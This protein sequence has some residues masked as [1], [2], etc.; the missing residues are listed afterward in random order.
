[1]LNYQALDIGLGNGAFSD[2]YLFQARQN[3]KMRYA[4]KIMFKEDLNPD[5]LQLVNEEVSIL[6]MLD[7]SNIVKYIESYEDDTNLFIV[8]EYLEDATELQKLINQKQEEMDKDPARKAESLFKEDEVCRVMR[9]IFGGLHHIHSNNVVHRDMKPE[10]CL[11]DK[12]GQVRIIDFGLSKMV[13]HAEEGQFLMGTPYFL[14]PE[15]HELEGANEA[16]RQPLDCWS[17]GVLMYHMI[18][19]KYPFDKPDLTEKICTGYV[20][21]YDDRFRN[22]S[23]HAKDLIRKLLTKDVETRCTAQNALQHEF[24]K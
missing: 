13:Q 24:F 16:Y 5:I 15:V 1:M 3:A 4:V 19:G 17:A 18:S 8:M 11:L 23:S 14:A 22:I 9:M 20:E 7:H 6:A 2:V 12:D 10:N 21:F